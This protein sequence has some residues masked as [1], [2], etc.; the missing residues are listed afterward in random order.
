MCDTLIK[1]VNGEFIFGKN[2]DR[3]CNEP[4]LTIY[5]PAKTNNDKE[6]QCTYLK[7]ENS[8]TSNGV[9][10]TKPSWMWGAEM[11]INDKGVII[12]NEAVFTKTKGKDKERLIGMDL[13][14]LG[15]ERGNSAKESLDIIISLLD[16]YGQGGNCGFDHKFFY[17]NSFLISDKN[18]AYILETADKKWVYKKIE[19]N[20]NISNRLS[21]NEGYTQTSDPKIINFAKENTEPIFTF[22]SKAK[23]RQETAH[24]ALNMRTKYNVESIMAILRSHQGEDKKD[25][26]TKGS[27]GSLCMHQSMLGDHTTGSMI[28]QSRKTIDTIWLTGCSTPCLAIYK[29][30]YFGAVVP[31]VFSNEGESLKYWMDREYLVRAIYSGLID[32]V[33][34]KNNLNALQKQF[35]EG[36]QKLISSKPTKNDLKE[37]AMKCHLY[38]QEFVNK[39]RDVIDKVKNN[40]LNLSSTWAR[41]TKNL[42]KNVYNKDLR[43]R[44]EK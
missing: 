1:K 16:K 9:I 25:L 20:G 6:L 36:D 24:K 15:L 43:K 5:I 8:K 22:F 35:I 31:P 17:D 18:E 14:R 11:G 34:Y 23:L 27:V 29:P 32:E 40:E 33:E 4:N 28:V 3:G 26:Y 37:Y 41:K 13:L 21:L 19:E 30:T 10:L 2:S 42:G 39:Y 38:E 12:G 44:C 7:I